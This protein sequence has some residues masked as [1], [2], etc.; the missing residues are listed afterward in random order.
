MTAISEML[1]AQRG[2]AIACG[3]DGIEC[4]VQKSVDG[5]D[6]VIHDRS[7]GCIGLS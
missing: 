7:V 1:L 5:C 2:Q 4:D 3:A 6:V